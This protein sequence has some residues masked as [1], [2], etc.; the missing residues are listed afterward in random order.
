MTPNSVQSYEL[1]LTKMA[2]LY[3]EKSYITGGHAGIN[4]FFQHIYVFHPIILL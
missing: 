3:S 2:N 1:K 4:T